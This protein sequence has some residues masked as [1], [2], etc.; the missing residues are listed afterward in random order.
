MAAAAKAAASALLIVTTVVKM[1]LPSRMFCKSTE[2]WFGFSLR[3][4]M[5]VV[6]NDVCSEGVKDSSV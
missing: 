2:T 6:L 5:I 3:K 4:L 1:M